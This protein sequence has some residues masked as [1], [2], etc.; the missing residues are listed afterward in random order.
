[1]WEK[2]IRF[3]FFDVDLSRAFEDREF[4]GNAVSP[5]VFVI[6][7]LTCPFSFQTKR[8]LRKRKAMKE[9]STRLGSLEERFAPQENEE[10]QR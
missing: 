9:I 1:L 10:V 5:A 2:G 4:P 6:R 7:I 8:L 3:V